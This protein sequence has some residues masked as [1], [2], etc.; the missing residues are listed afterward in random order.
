MLSLAALLIIIGMIYSLIVSWLAYRHS[1]QKWML[2]FPQWID[3]N[4]GI[5]ARL[6]YHGMIAFAVLLVGMALL[7]A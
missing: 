6:R 3:R 7:L 1:G 5:P 4:C 2:L